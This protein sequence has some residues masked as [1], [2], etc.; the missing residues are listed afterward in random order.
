MS[1]WPLRDT[2][3][4][5][6]SPVRV[7]PL[8]RWPLLDSATTGQL[9]MDGIVVRGPTGHSNEYVDGP[10]LSKADGCSQRRRAGRKS[11]ASTGGRN[12][13]VYATNGNAASL[14]GDRNTRSAVETTTTTTDSDHDRHRGFGSMIRQFLTC[15][16]TS[17]DVQNDVVDFC[18]SGEMAGT[19]CRRCGR[20]RCT[21]CACSEESVALCRARTVID[22]VTCMCCVRSVFYHCLKDDAGDEDDC[23]DEPC[24]CCERPH[25]A[26]RWTVMAL[27]LPCLPCL[28]LYPALSCTVEAMGRRRHAGRA[29]RCSQRSRPPGLKGLLESESSST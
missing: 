24:S 26:A 11:P 21:E 25:C 19:V 8:T 13:A 4:H 27:L 1:R 14:P 5:S 16:S 10:S 9:T 15:S 3:T 18:R 12:A 6:T 2:A 20:C 29:C 22:T 28:C 7:I 17:P 23:S